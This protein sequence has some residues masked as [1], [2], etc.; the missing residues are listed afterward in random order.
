[1]LKM[2]KFAWDLVGVYMD[3][4]YGVWVWEIGE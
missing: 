3:G 1:M 4:D 2:L